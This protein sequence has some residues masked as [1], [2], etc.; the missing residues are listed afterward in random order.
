[1]L[2]KVFGLVS[3]VVGLSL[4]GDELEDKDAAVC[5]KDGSEDCDGRALIW[6]IVLLEL[7]GWEVEGRGVLENRLF[8]NE[9]SRG[10]REGDL[11]GRVVG[12][13]EC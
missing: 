5:L 13:R 4:G 2:E 1:M 11:A 10:E 6:G 7:L 9:S 8:L 3:E 12:L